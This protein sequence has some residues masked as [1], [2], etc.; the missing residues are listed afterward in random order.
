[1]NPLVKEY[2]GKIPQKLLNDLEAE[3]QNTKLTNDQL[4]KVLETE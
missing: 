3:L 4:K 1:M 2:E